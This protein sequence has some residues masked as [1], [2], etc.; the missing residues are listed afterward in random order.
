M[1]EVCIMALEKVL[2]AECTDNTEPVTNRRMRVLPK[3][4]TPLCT[5]VCL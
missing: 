2:P 1:K 4:S 3:V 5:V